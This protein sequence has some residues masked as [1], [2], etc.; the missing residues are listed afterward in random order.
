[1]YFLCSLLMQKVKKIEMNK[2]NKIDNEFNI[3]D[4][5]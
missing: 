4:K 3:E 5:N 1:M 2:D